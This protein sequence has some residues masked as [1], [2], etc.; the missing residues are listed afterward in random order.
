MM[1]DTI[2]SLATAITSPADQELPLLESLCACAEAQIA[3]RLSDGTA[4]EDCA[5]AF[6][7]AA[8]LYAAAG[9]FSCRSSGGV[10][11]FTAGEVSIR[12]AAAG[13]RGA[14]LRA[15]AERLM[16]PY[17]DSGGGGAFAFREVP[18]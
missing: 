17:S 10:E 13:S 11:Q 9:L 8:A 14:E 1:H 6:T 2:L 3:G 16:A 15:L 7:C 4:P 18:G 5:E 12:T